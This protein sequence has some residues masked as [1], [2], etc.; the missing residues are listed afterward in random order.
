MFLPDLSTKLIQESYARIS[1]VYVQVN[2]K[3]TSFGYVFIPQILIIRSQSFFSKFSVLLLARKVPLD[4]TLAPLLSLVY[5]LKSEAKDDVLD[6]KKT[7]QTHPV[8]CSPKTKFQK[9]CRRKC[10][11]TQLASSVMDRNARGGTLTKLIESSGRT[12]HLES[13]QLK[14][15]VTYFNIVGDAI[16]PFIVEEK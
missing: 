3:C 10:A 11:T 14:H 1:Y 5:L 8:L 13:S 2:S 9:V 7:D 6:K 4:K 16:V 15:L 12:C